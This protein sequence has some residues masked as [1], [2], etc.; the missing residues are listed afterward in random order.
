MGHLKNHTENMGTPGK[1]V[2]N[3]AKHGQTLRKA[4]NNE[5]NMGKTCL[6]LGV[7]GIYMDLLANGLQQFH[8]FIYIYIYIY[9][10]TYNTHID[11]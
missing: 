10:S 9:I 8:L 6:L 3:R 11:M 1:M 2:E 7:F 4:R 5:R